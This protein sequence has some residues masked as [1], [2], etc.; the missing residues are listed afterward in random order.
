MQESSEDSSSDLSK[1]APH[2]ENLHYHADLLAME[3]K[4]RLVVLKLLEKPVD[5][6]HD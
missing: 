1:E 6:M 2:N 5:L 4:L 3:N